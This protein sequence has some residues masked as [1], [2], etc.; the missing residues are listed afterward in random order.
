MQS[1]VY[2]LFFYIS[3]YKCGYLYT[4]T[5]NHS[6]ILNSSGIG[7]PSVSWEGHSNAVRP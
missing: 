5:Y 3:S 6:I 2:V 4:Q 1:A 7:V